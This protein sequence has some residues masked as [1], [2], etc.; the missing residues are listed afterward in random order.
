MPIRFTKIFES[1]QSQLSVH[2]KMRLWG[3]FEFIMVVEYV[4]DIG[5]SKGV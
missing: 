3:D 1:V 5:V 2:R 4:D